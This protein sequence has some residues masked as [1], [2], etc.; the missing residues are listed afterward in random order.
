MKALRTASTLAIVAALLVVSGCGGDDG[1]TS[2]GLAAATEEVSASSVDQLDFTW[3]DTARLR[4]VA[5]LP[6]SFDELDDDDL[7]WQT[8]TGLTFGF[9]LGLQSEAIDLGFEPLAGDRTVSVGDSGQYVS[10][11]DGVDTDAIRSGLEELDFEEQGDFLALG[12]EGE[13]VETVT[14]EAGVAAIGINRAAFEDDSVAFGGYEDPV[15]AALGD[16]GTPVGDQPGVSA[17][18]DCLGDSVLAA[19]LIAP[20]G[21]FASLKIGLVGVGV[22][23]PDSAS[24]P[25]P[26]IVCVV[27]ADGVSLDGVADSVEEGFAEGADPRTQ[28]PF[29]DEL[30]EV[31]VEEGETDDTP[32]IRA[33]F[34]EPPTER[35]GTTFEM[36][37]NQSFG[38]VLGGDPIGVLGPRATPAEIREYLRT[39]REAGLIP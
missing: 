17:A 34:A 14:D 27:A 3:V 2:G 39:Q 7:R 8:L 10:R 25:V 1:S 30:G 11:F 6:D 36:L 23:E 12:E 35:V 16:G 13:L 33:T 5:E 19:E 24:A 22:E 38:V 37:V 28:V 21:S 18:V 4:E 32:W 9:E 29:T 15:A 26:E 31:S 20:Q